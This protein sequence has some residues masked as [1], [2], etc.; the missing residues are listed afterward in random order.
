MAFL[1][2]GWFLILAQVVAVD[3]LLGGDNAM[4]I[5][6]ACR[7][8]PG[9]MRQRAMM[10]GMIGALFARLALA[11]VATMLID[12]PT[13]R[14]LGGLLLG[15]IAI[16]LA[17]PPKSEEDAAPFSASAQA[18][19]VGLVIVVSDLVM[20][21]DNVVALAAITR[22]DYLML[23]LGLLLSIPALMWGAV[24]M[25]G[26]L[27]RHSWTIQAGAALMGWIAG[28][29]AISDRLYGDWIA[30]Q[31]PALAYAAPAAMA[32]YVVLQARMLAKAPRHRRKQ[33]TPRALTVA[34][35][36][37]RVKPVALPPPAPKPAPVVLSPKPAPAPVPA[38]ATSGP[39]KYVLWIFAGLALAITLLLGVVIF[40]GDGQI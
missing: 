4:L 25:T 33:A 8:L 17:L 18:L 3:L 30:T 31:S 29:F 1:S 37:K 11:S 10:V 38:E 20:S 27:K 23:A 36:V 21:L 9:A 13:L 6:L 15:A 39:E 35:P 32:V 40:L 22:G 26:L 14:L 19:G 2:S 24:L 28:D 7:D 34:T 16:N 5:A 12:I